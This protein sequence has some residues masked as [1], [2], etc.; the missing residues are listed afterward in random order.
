MM[1]SA[2]ELNA[3]VP[4]IGTMGVDEARAAVKSLAPQTV[5]AAMQSWNELYGRELMK[6]AHK[7]GRAKRLKR[8]QESRAAA[9]ASAI[10]ARAAASKKGK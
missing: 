6:D 8:I 3:L 2:E 9:R 4:G 7:A 5:N 1:L 10:A